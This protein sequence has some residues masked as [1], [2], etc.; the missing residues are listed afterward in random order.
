MKL[1]LEKVKYAMREG[2]FEATPKFHISQAL[3]CH[4]IFS[5]SELL[6]EVAETIINHFDLAKRPHLVLDANSASALCLATFI[7]S[8]LSRQG[9]SPM[10][11]L[12]KDDRPLCDRVYLILL[13]N[14]LTDDEIGIR[15]NYFKAKGAFVAG[16]TGICDRRQRKDGVRGSVQGVEVWTPLDLNKVGVNVNLDDGP[17]QLCLEGKPRTQSLRVI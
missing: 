7:D 8:A 2:H 17:C 3:L 12:T 5:D 14:V 10:T 13:P 1:A 9:K 6:K 4:Y 11:I 15:I 16:A